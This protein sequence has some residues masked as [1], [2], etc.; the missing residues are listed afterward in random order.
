MP[1]IKSDP[2]STPNN[3]DGDQ[4]EDDED[5]AVIT[6]NVGQGTADL[7]LTKEV[8]N[9][10]PNVGDTVTFTITVNNDGPDDATNVGISD[11]V[12]TGYTNVSAISN[13]GQLN[14]SSINWAIAIIPV[15]TNISVTFTADVLTPTGA[16]NEYLNTAQISA[17]DQLDSDS[18]PN[19]DDGDQSEDDE[20]SAVVTPGGVA[21]TADLSLTKDVSTTSPSSGDIVTFTITVT[22]DGP[23]DATNVEVTDVVPTG[24]VDIQNV[25]N[26]GVVNGNIITWPITSLVVN[27]SVEL[28]FDVEV[29]SVLNP[30]TEY[31]NTA[32][33][34]A[35]DQDDI[36]STPNNDDGDQS[37]DDEDSATVAPVVD[38]TGFFYCEDNGQILTGGSVAFNPVASTIVTSDGS[39]GS[40][41]IDFNP[42]VAA[43]LTQ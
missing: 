20:D 40:Y 36:D 2:D 16:A 7:S 9:D 8:D 24:Y 38:P 11:V 13:D 18:T 12:P 4:S 27:N 10:A 34:T 21:G 35:S 3:D 39:N 31:L 19:N 22:N 26:A 43:P 25:S 5:N 29:V 23:A 28:T 33:I 1:V 32:Q 17:S 15:N 30:S 37:E 6:P 41:Q 14:G 42:A